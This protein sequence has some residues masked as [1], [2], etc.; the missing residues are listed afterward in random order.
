M[1]SSSS[2]Y[3]NAFSKERHNK[4]P[5]H[6]SIFINNTLIHGHLAA[7]SLDYL[8]NDLSLI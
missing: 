7:I 1:L 2:I 4:S 8:Y 6:L 5:A 3:V